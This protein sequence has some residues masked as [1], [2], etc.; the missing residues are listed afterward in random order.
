[1]I[2]IKKFKKKLNMKDKGNWNV[3]LNS[4]DYNIIKI[5]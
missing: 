2:L 5:V 1:M 4:F 3:L